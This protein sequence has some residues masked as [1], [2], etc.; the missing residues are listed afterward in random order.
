[1]KLR[2]YKQNKCGEEKLW[3]KLKTLNIGAEHVSNNVT[4][5]FEQC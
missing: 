5:R 3:L 1:M 4:D 2:V